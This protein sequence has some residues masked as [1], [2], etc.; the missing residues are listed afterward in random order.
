MYSVHYQYTLSIVYTIVILNVQCT[1]L[2]Y[3][4]TV[5]IISTLYVHYQYTLCTLLVHLM[6]TISTP[7]VHYQ[8]TLCTLLVH[9]VYTI[10]TRYVHCTLLVHLIYS[11]HSQLE[12]TKFRETQPRKIKFLYNSLKAHEFFNNFMIIWIVYCKCTL[13]LKVPGHRKNISVKHSISVCKLDTNVIT[14]SMYINNEI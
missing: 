8:Y 9:L 6:Y 5:Y 10:C 3:L 12:N 14:V 2:V 4:C 7:Y 13:I 1:L 11:V